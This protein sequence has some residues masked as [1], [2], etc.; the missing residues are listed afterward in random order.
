MNKVIPLEKLAARLLWQKYDV[1]WANGCFD[2]LHVG[3]IRMLREAASRGHVLV[4]GVNS[5][6]SVRRL[7][8]SGRPVVPEAQRAEML[9][10]LPFVDHVVIFGGDTAGWCIRLL[11]PAVVCKGEL[12][13][14]WESVDPN[15]VNPTRTRILARLPADE[16]LAIGDVRA[17]LVTLPHTPGVSTTDIIHR[18]RTGETPSPASAG[19]SPPLRV[20]GG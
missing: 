20:S 16:V 1:V 11:R 5:D 4:V 18:L 14:P 3:H 10:V 17:E 19:E 12:C 2:L 8:G 6:E 7:K 9:A 13:T 15:A